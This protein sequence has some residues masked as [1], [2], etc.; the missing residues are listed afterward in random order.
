MINNSG[1]A[2]ACILLRADAM[3]LYR[4]P[5]QLFFA[6]ESFAEFAAPCALLKQPKW[7]LELQQT[8]S[9]KVPLGAKEDLACKG[10]LF[11]RPDRM[12][13][14]PEAGEGNPLHLVLSAGGSRVD[15]LTLETLAQT[16]LLWSVY[17]VNPLQLK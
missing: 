15:R 6:S 12:L 1:C 16:P 13:L 10:K 4:P 3:C 7:G 9:L 8:R 2:E 17:L 14:E 11:S 5:A